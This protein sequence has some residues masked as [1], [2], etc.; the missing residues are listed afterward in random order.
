MKAV[1]PGLWI[2]NAADAR[3]V[4]RVVDLGIMA[5]LHLAMEDPPV[6]YPRDIVYCRFPLIDG[7]GNR[8]EVVRAAVGTLRNLI[9]VDAPTLVACS[10]GVS[11][12]PAIVAAA[13]SQTLG[14]SLDDALKRLV[15]LA[16]HDISPALWDEIKRCG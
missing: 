7:V 16:P 13:W 12:A 8:P 11:R 6:G 10:G 14:V 3:D 9:E 5:V 15:A 2:G 4:R 1:A